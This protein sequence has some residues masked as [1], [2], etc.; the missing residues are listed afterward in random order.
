MKYLIDANI[1]LHA[2]LQQDSGDECKEFLDRVSSGEIEAKVTMFH[3]DAS[4]I[5]MENRG[6]SREDIGNFYFEAYS[7]E[8]LEIVNAGV[9]AR[10]D[11]LASS[12]HQGLDDGLLLQ[13]FEE[14][15]VDRIVAYDTDFEEENRTTPEEILTDTT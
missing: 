7:S 15:E 6:L 10:L 5:I 3:L 14:L 12:K 4:A 8:G 13:A 2:A 11:A 1:F 9:S